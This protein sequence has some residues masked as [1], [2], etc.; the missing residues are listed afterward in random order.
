MAA[1][2]A[3]EQDLGG[4]PTLA[5]ALP[6]CPTG[7]LSLEGR[8]AS[9][10]GRKVGSMW[11]AN[12][13]RD[14]GLQPA[15]QAVQ[16]VGRFNLCRQSQLATFS[17]GFAEAPVTPCCAALTVCSAASLSCQLD[18]LPTLCCRNM[19]AARPFPIHRCSASC[20][21]RWA[22]SFPPRGR[23]R[24]LQSSRM[25]AAGICLFVLTFHDHI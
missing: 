3:P 8:C 5:R 24:S 18:L 20:P 4:G 7:T 13:P 19:R 17:A 14:E 21:G 16:H 9:G 22:F 25:S 23:A 12:L 11:E 1:C 6:R 15:E 2:I 10:I